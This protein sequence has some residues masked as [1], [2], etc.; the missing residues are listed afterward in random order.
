MY[1][2]EPRECKISKQRIPDAFF[3][4]QPAT[5]F[6]RRLAN[7]RTKKC[8]RVLKIVP[9]EKKR[10][11]E[12]FEKKSSAMRIGEG[13][14]GVVARNRETG[15]KSIGRKGDIVYRQRAPE[16]SDAYAP[17]K[18]AASSAYKCPERE[19]FNRSGESG[20]SPRCKAGVRAYTCHQSTLRRVANNV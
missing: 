13:G 9:G 7:S 20:K 6:P 16:A 17:L 19:F 10:L 12:A 4:L 14:E 11:G 3:I 15:E 1:I 5:T 2:R 18:S 8:R